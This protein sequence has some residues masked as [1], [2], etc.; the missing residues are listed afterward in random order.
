MH[1]KFFWDDSFSIRNTIHVYPSSI[2][3][4]INSF[5][6]SCVLAHLQCAFVIGR[7]QLTC[8]PIALN[9]VLDFGNVFTIYILTSLWGIFD[10][11][12]CVQNIVLCHCFRWL[13]VSQILSAII[14][15]I[16]IH[17]QQEASQVKYGVFLCILY[18]NFIFVEQ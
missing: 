11:A 5:W 13:F 7:T 15:T 8:L 12:G 10:Q 4:S 14:C 1:V 16:V 17:T 9:M 6:S 3:L 2:S 18:Q